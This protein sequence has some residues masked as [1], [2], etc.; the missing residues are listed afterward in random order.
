MRR[1]RDTGGFSLLEALVA[2][3]LVSIVL[4]GA[5]GAFATQT[6][7]YRQ[8]DLTTAT[9]QNLRVAMGMVVDALRSG[10]Y[11]APD[12]DLSA[13]VPWVSGFA[14]SPMITGTA[15]MTVSVASCFQ[16]PLATLSAAV[17]GGATILSVATDIPGQSIPDLLNRT[18]MSLILV[19]D[20]ENA[21]VTNVTESALAIDTDPNTVGTQ[22]LARGYPAGTP[23]CRVDVHTFSISTDTITGVSWMAIDADQGAGPQP[24]IDG[25]S[26]LTVTAVAAHQYQV[27]LTAR[28]ES[29]DPMTQLY[30]TR[31]LSSNVTLRN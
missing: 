26:H 20:S 10:G 15:P 11:G 5:V 12:G 8:Q 30:V 6:R 7:S 9:Q 29:I 2:L 16:A 3:L 4:A 22:G 19:G 17:T 25:I 1:A 27:T 18:T 31:S 24:A 14:S 21:Q 28:S 23:I 13:W